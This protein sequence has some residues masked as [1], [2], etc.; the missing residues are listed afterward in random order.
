MTSAGLRPAAKGHHA[1]EPP[2]A[3]SPRH[4][5]LAPLGGPPTEPDT[6]EKRRNRLPPY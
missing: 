6:R 2:R 4:S 3:R 5:N 1:L